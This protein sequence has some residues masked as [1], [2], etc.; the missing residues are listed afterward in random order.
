MTTPTTSLTFSSI[1]TEFGGANPI[2]IS[3]Y[4]R[5]AGGGYVPAGQATSATDGNA[6]A[7]SGAIRIGT[8]R[9]VTK[10]VG[11]TVAM[12]VTPTQIAGNANASGSV[13]ATFSMLANGT[14]TGSA[15]PITDTNDYSA[16]W[17][18]PTTAGIGSSYWVRVTPTAG[19]FTSGTSGTWVSLSSGQAWSKNTTG[20]GT[21]TVTY[22]LEISSSSSGTPVLVTKTGC[23]LTYVHNYVL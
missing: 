17:A 18:S 12:A 23:R 20:S 14:C 1:Q 15:T 10:T 8:F 21:S 2:S 11:V 4:Y 3:E 19:A 16:N 9:G 13:N 22:T 7:T 5:G 6:I